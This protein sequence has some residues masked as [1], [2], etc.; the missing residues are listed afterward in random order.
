MTCPQ[1]V[2]RWVQNM[3]RNLVPY[4]WRVMLFLACHVLNVACHGVS[5]SI[6]SIS[7]VS[8]RVRI[9]R[10]SVSVPCRGHPDSTAAANVKA[11]SPSKVPNP[12]QAEEALEDVSSRAM[13][14][15]KRLAGDKKMSRTSRLVPL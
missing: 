7:S 3:L 11:Q 14:P 2:G 6:V 10:V 13:P 12:I 9:L 5:I 1:L 4:F 8:C 15:L